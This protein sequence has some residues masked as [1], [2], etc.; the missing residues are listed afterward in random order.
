MKNQKS[1]K[2]CKF[3][4]R[5]KKGMSG[6]IA[7]IL[8]VGLVVIAVA[9]VGV[10]VQNMISDQTEG[11]EACFGNFDKVKINN[12]YTC[13]DSDLN[14]F[15]F[16]LSIKD[17]TVDKV[18][19]AIYGDGA[20]KSF[21][22]N[23]TP[24]PINGVRNYKSATYPSGSTNINLSSKNG[25]LTYIYDLATGGFSDAP[26]KIEIVPTLNGKQCDTSDSLTNIEVC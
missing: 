4:S 26:D 15:R 8:L 1:K 10:V 21:E 25:G 7:M 23:N 9:I 3:F 18:L 20:T 5:N 19:V 13:Y 24:S 11:T 2:I 17:V 16:S 14:L 6:V 12:L 22:I